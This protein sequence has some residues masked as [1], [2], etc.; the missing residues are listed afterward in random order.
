MI[1]LHGSKDL[2]IG[3]PLAEIPGIHSIK[4]KKNTFSVFNITF[5]NSDFSQY[6]DGSIHITKRNGVI[7]TRA[8][9]EQINKQTAAEVT[10]IVHYTTGW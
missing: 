4:G 6:S 2:N 5:S 9:C 7:E 10:A 8:L 3:I 1:F